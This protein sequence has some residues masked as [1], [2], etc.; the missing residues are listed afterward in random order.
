MI[1][2]SGSNKSCTGTY[3]VLNKP[4]GRCS[5]HGPRNPLQLISFCFYNFKVEV[6]AFECVMPNSRYCAS[7]HI[8]TGTRSSSYFVPFAS[9]TVR[10]ANVPGWAAIYMYDPQSDR[11]LHNIHSY[12]HRHQTNNP[13]KYNHAAGKA[14]LHSNQ[15]VHLKRT[16]AYFRYDG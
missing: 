13:L 14:H 11:I 4:A 2:L 6:E 1:G 7:Q 5:S 16:S 12:S 8:C 9:E 10:F 3:G 15:R